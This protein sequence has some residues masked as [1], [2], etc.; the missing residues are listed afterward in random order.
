[1]NF[2]GLLRTDYHELCKWQE[3]QRRPTFRPSAKVRK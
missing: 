3:S 2:G 1:M